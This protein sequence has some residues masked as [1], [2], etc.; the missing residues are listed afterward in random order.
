M[1][2]KE[3]KIHKAVK[4][5]SKPK[6]YGYIPDKIEDHHYLFGSGQLGGQILQLTGQWD[7]F[8]PADEFQYRNGLETYNCTGFGT[9]HATA[10]LFKR[11]FSNDFNKSER[12][13]GIVAGTSGSG[14]SPHTVAEAI[15]INGFI[16]EFSLPFSP[17]I[18]TLEEYYAPKPPT[19][20][21]TQEG[22]QWLQQYTF[23]HDWVFS[24]NTDPAR[25][26]E[27]MKKALQYSP[28][29][30]SVFA[31]QQNSDGLYVSQDYQ[32]HWVTLYGYEDGK[33]WKIFDSYDSTHK[34]LVWEFNFGVAKRYV[35][36][37][38]TTLTLWQK[39]WQ[40]LRN[41]FHF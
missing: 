25:N 33:Y 23:G 36:Q 6:N 3:R 38:K 13:I 17:D 28:L 2:R 31:W 35:V 24:D 19:P 37:K 5:V 15:R 8:L 40:V 9:N 41:F 14:N 21:L 26:R 20:S 12:F 22:L 18:Q 39:T 1:K 10:T 16:E 27:L 11:L 32:N 30:V 7:A 34:Q 29:G 4:T